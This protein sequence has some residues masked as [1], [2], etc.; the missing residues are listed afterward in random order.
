MGEGDGIMVCWGN[1][2]CEV[3]GSEDKL[4]ACCK[5]LDFKLSFTGS[6]FVTLTIN[7]FVLGKKTS[8]TL[9]LLPLLGS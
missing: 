5:T 7:A 9:F 8:L 1:V 3:V 2:G 4:L 6:T